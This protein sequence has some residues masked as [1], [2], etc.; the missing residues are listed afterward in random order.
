[1]QTEKSELCE[2][3][4]TGKFLLYYR[5]TPIVP[6]TFQGKVFIQEKMEREYAYFAG[7]LIYTGLFTGKGKFLSCGKA[8]EAKN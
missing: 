1:M 6:K 3:L 2:L 4:L 5:L 8:Q 7:Y